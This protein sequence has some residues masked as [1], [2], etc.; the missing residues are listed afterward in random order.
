[1]LLVSGLMQVS[2]CNS[3]VRGTVG[4]IVPF[5][6]MDFREAASNK[7]EV[8]QPRKRRVIT[9][10]GSQIAIFGD[11]NQEGDNHLIH[12][13]SCVLLKIFLDTANHTYKL[14]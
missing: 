13:G 7:L 2:A 3:E 10:I 9:E 5:C 14:F 11:T 8:A 1:M 6:F 12:P 4:S